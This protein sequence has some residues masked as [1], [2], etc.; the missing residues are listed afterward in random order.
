MRAYK[1][2]PTL[3]KIDLQRHSKIQEK[4]IEKLSMRAH[5][6]LSCPWPKLLK[7]KPYLP[8]LIIQPQSTISALLKSSIVYLLKLGGFST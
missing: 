7:N 1:S 8:D 5:I 6:H 2:G 3:N 4:V